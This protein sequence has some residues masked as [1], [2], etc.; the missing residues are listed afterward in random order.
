MTDPSQS[1]TE[2]FT[3]QSS[4]RTYVRLQIT[5]NQKRALSQSGSYADL[6]S[7]F[8]VYFLCCMDLMM[9]IAV[10]L[11]YVNVFDF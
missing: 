6:L 5:Q 11:L 10:A 7:I 1:F 3:E 8:I 4:N 9:M 2:A